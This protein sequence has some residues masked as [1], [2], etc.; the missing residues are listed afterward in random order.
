MPFAIHQQFADVRWLLAFRY[1]YIIF[2]GN[3]YTHTHTHET[4]DIICGTIFSFGNS[5][6]NFPERLRER[7]SDKM[8]SRVK[9]LLTSISSRQLNGK[10]DSVSLRSVFST[11]IFD[12]CEYVFVCMWLFKSY[13][14]I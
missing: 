11:P 7:A 10:N 5:V 4:C 3:Q 8:I 12:R 6:I 14:S 13:T 2:P 1:R 9:Y